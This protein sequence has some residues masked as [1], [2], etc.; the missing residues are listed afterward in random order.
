MTVG[1]MGFIPERLLM[2]MMIT[3]LPVFVKT[4][5][6]ID[7]IYYLFI[8][9]HE[10]C[11][12]ALLRKH[13]DRIMPCWPK[14]FRCLGPGGFGSGSGIYVDLDLAYIWIWPGFQVSRSG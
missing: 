6:Q 9:N 11:M 14:G 7:I 12:K 2:M 10:C 8:M 5:Q 1:G 3:G 4:G 13:K